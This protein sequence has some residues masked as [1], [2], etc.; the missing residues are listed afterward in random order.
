M[1]LNDQQ[2]APLVVLRLPEVCRRTGLGRTSV[3]T[4]SK[5]GEMPGP[6]SLGG[7]R[8]VGWIEHEIQ[9]WISSRPRVSK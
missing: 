5:S 1:S 2:V 4:M 7:R 9:S 6:V 3:L 8:A